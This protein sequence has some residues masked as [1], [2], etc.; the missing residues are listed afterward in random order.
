MGLKCWIAGFTLC[1]GVTG[2]KPA[3]A[4]TPASFAVQVFLQDDAGVPAAVLEQAKQAAVHVFALSSID[5]RWIG[6]GPSLAM[7]AR[8][9]GT[10]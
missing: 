2:S 9:C 6:H 3:S 10:P 7:A 8:C 4:Q 1:V 5:L